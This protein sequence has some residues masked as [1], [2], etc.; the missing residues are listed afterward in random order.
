MYA[1]KQLDKKESLQWLKTIQRNLS[2]FLK[3]GFDPY[4]P[5]NNFEFD[6]EESL[7]KSIREAFEFALNIKKSTLA[8][9]SHQ[10]LEGRM[11]RFE[12][13]LNENGFKNR[14]ITSVN[15]KVAPP[16][17]LPPNSV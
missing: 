13:W 3:D 11:L 5:N 10:G 16:T 12:K 2:I 14:I 7:S 1:P 6:T 4:N 15:K 9:T 17:T 8:G